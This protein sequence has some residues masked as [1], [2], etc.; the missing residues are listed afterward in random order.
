MN[1]GLKR[2]EE[3]HGKTE[4]EVPEKYVNAPTLS[5][6]PARLRISLT[7]IALRRRYQ[8][9]V[10]SLVL[11]PAWGRPILDLS[12]STSTQSGPAEGSSGQGTFIHTPG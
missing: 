7:A 11:Q 1:L 9:M 4:N 5:F 2:A 6:W 12:T 10:R 8:G 3:N